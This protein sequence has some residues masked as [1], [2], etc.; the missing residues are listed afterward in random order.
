MTPI[1]L[2][3]TKLPHRNPFGAN[4]TR[5]HATA[6]FRCCAAAFSSVKPMRSGTEIVDVVFAGVAVFDFGVASLS[7][8]IP[9]GAPSSP[10][11]VFPATSRL[12]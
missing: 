8:T 3:T 6:V 4:P 7:V 9:A 2:I 1:F 12:R 5:L 11:R 10:M